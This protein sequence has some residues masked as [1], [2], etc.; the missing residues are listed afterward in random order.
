M[1][2]VAGVI[3]PHPPILIPEIGDSRLAE[4]GRTVAAMR[5][6]SERVAALE[7]ETLIFLS[8]HSPGLPDSFVIKGERSLSGSFAGFGC[9]SIVLE[10]R[11]DL[12]L[13]GEIDSACRLADVPIIA[14]KR[15]TVLDWGV[16]VPAYFLGLDGRR[17]VS[18]SISD[19]SLAAH[20]ALGRALGSAVHASGKRVVIVAS[21]DLSH[22][23]TADAPY[24][25]S[26]RGREFDALVEK[27][28]AA[29]DFTKLSEIDYELRQ[30]AAECGLRSFVALGGALQATTAF[31]PEVLSYEGPFG[32]GYLVALA[33]VSA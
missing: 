20:A 10:G 33:V 32:V 3:A 16:L 27:A 29:G 22:R 6:L 31:T 18:L 21:G 19:L 28:V 24:G 14:L 9:P 12:Q 11:N 1:P 7:P 8:P 25:Y 23:L 26:K 2:L 4:A 5:R 15:S 13:A 30:E 17:L